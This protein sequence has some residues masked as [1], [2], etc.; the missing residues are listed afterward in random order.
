MAL[1]RSAAEQGECQLALT[2]N[3]TPV[4]WD[5]VAPPGWLPPWTEV[6]WISILGYPRRLWFL[7]KSGYSWQQ[8]QREEIIRKG[9]EVLAATR[10]AET[11]APSTT[12]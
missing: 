6:V 1:D 11:P 3:E 10:A 4:H 5:D 2:I 7:S 12:D 8:R 9:R